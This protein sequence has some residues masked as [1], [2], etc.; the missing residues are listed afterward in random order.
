MG[1]G[2]ITYGGPKHGQFQPNPSFD[3]M[4]E[5]DHRFIRGNHDSPIACKKHKYWIPDG[6]LRNNMMFI[7]GAVSIDKQWRVRDYSWW[8]DEEPSIP[9]LNTM[10]DIYQILKPE[11]MVTHETTETVAEIICSH[12]KRQKMF[13]GS[14]CRQAFQSMWDLHKPKIWVHGHHH[15]TF[16]QII[17]GT[18][19]ICL[20]ELEWIDLNID[21][22]EI[23]NKGDRNGPFKIAETLEVKYQ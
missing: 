22:L 9:E 21:T 23:V 4:S 19:F 12:N 10:V 7:G 8:P 16:D 1:I 14:R 13:D 18:R 6:S 20:N 3:T 17:D 5:G 15:Y 2:F 11:I